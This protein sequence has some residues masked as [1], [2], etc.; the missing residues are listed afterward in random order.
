[1]LRR[2]FFVMLSASALLPV[3]PLMA[4]DFT[5]TIAYAYTHHPALKAEQENMEA[6]R[7]TV[8]EAYSG[9]MPTV[10]AN[11]EHGRKRFEFEG[12]DQENVP[13]TNKVLSVSQPLFQGGGTLAQIRTARSLSQAEEARLYAAGQEVLFKAVAAYA[14]M[15]EAETLLEINRDNV[16]LLGKHMEATRTRRKAKDVTITDLA[17]SEARQARAEADLSDAE[18]NYDSA[19]ATY[20]REIGREPRAVEKLPPLPPHLPDS[21]EDVA[22]LSERHPSLQAARHQENAADSTVDS[23][24]ATILPSVSLQGTAQEQDGISTLSPSLSRLREEAVMV[25][26]SIPLYQSGAEYARLSQ[27]RHRHQKA[28]N[29]TLDTVRDTRENA[30]KAWDDFVAAQGAVAGN[31]KATDAAQHALAGIQ[32]EYKYGTRTV[33]DV[34]DTQQEFFAARRGLIRAQTQRVISA[35]RLLA[36]I[37]S[38]DPQTL[39]L[40]VGKGAPVLHTEEAEDTPVAVGK[41]AEYTPPPPPVS[42]S[43]VLVARMMPMDG[44]GET[45]DIPLLAPAAGTMKMLGSVSAQPDPLLQ[46]GTE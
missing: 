40:N 26:V 45:I 21:R 10:T 4:D 27:A 38:L 1:M 11:Y 6:S 14:R 31:Q 35:Y 7:D 41:Q 42:A 23:R 37:G 25:K 33:L 30:L 46:P 8:W 44:E 29:D 20:I 39:K 17:L 43:S 34:L 28:R 24:V 3:W 16:N 22:K 9:F 15:V 36:A 19:R 13:T 2:L 32:E 12:A 18:G 5:D